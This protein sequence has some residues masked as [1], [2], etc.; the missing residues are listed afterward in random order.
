MGQ[1]NGELTFKALLTS[2]D[3]YPDITNPTIAISD[4]TVGGEIGQNLYVLD[5]FAGVTLIVIEASSVESST[6]P[7]F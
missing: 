7:S 1:T 2:E 3:I 6:S 5:R 4:I